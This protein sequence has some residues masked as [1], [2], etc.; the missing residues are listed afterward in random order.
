M[1][2]LAK[3][4]VILSVVALLAMTGAL[5][6][7][8]VKHANEAQ[9]CINNINKVFGYTRMMDKVGRIRYYVSIVSNNGNV[10]YDLQVDPDTFYRIKSEYE[11]ELY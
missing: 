11:K 6:F 5:V 4:I 7:S 1:E 2:T 10:C 9:D 8:A 3:L